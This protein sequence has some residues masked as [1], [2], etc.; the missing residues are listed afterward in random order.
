MFLYKLWVLA[1]VPDNPASVRVGTE[2]RALVGNSNR[3]ATRLADAWGVE[4]PPVPVNPSFLHGLTIPVGSNHR[5]C[6]PGFTF[7]I[8]FRY[9]T[10]NHEMMI[11]VRHGSFSMH[12]LPLKSTCTY[13][14]AVPHAENVRQR[15][16]N[17]CWS[18]ILGNL[19][20]YRYHSAIKTVLATF[21]AK[22]KRKTLHTQS[23]QWV[24]ME[25]PRLL[26]LHLPSY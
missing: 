20:G 12:W 17:D 21:I 6:I 14:H 3:Q 13:T 11:L 5:F 10:D 8:A 16:V 2:P 23:W 18:C 22:R 24:S 26:V 15:S 4:P 19:E 7:M 1:R 9:A 25:T